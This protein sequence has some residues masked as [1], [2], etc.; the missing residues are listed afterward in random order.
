MFGLG[1]ISLY[2]GYLLFF[3]LNHLQVSYLCSRCSLVFWFL[4]S[5][6]YINT[7][8][9]LYCLIAAALIYD[10]QAMQFP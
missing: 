2:V 5:D 7:I 10:F 8:H 9:Q 4:S 1:S 3:N 6:S